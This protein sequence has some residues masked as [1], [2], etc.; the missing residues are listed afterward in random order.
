M[1]EKT[2]VTD[3][4]EKMNVSKSIIETKISELEEIFEQQ[5]SAIKQYQGAIAQLEREANSTVGAIAVLKELL[6][7]DD[8]A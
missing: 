7:E 2:P 3:K 6:Q 5:K 1:A 4:L 8:N